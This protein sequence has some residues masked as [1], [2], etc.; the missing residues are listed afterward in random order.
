MRAAST[1]SRNVMMRA[2]SIL[3]YGYPTCKQF[4]TILKQKRRRN[5]L[6]LCMEL[7]LKFPG[8]PRQIKQLVA[9][10][11]ATGGKRLN[12]LLRDFQ[13][14]PIRTCLDRPRNG[15]AQAR[16]GVVVLAAK[17]SHVFPELPLEPTGG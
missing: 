10:H 9:N 3:L 5:R 1:P 4:A 14:E 6:P 13:N 16:V 17:R 11:L 12:G 2:C 8:T 7:I 15:C